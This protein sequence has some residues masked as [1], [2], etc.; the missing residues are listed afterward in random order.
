M[1]EVELQFASGSTHRPETL[2]NLSGVGDEAVPVAT[3][4][5]HRELTV[6]ADA[7]AA[8]CTADWPAASP[9]PMAVT[10]TAHSIVG[11]HRFISGLTGDTPC[12][13]S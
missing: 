3:Y 5:A 7:T 13:V 11:H 6:T 9:A 10:N 2:E 12:R 1:V 4:P 8:P